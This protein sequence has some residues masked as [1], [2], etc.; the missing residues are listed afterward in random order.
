MAGSIDSQVFNLG[1]GIKAKLEETGFTKF[2][3]DVESGVITLSK[4]GGFLKITN[5]SNDQMKLVRQGISQIKTPYN[6]SCVDSNT[7]NP[8]DLNMKAE[9]L[10]KEPKPL[11]SSAIKIACDLFKILPHIKKL[12]TLPPIR[13]EGLLNNGQYRKK[14]Y[15]HLSSITDFSEFQLFRG[16]QKLETKP[17]ENP[18]SGAPAKLVEKI[19]SSSEFGTVSGMQVSTEIVLSS[20]T[21]YI[22][23]HLLTLE[24]EERLIK[25]KEIINNLSA[26]IWYSIKGQDNDRASQDMSRR[27]LLRFHLATL[28]SMHKLEM[29]CALKPRKKNETIKA[30][31]VRKIVK[32]SGGNLTGKSL[33]LIIQ[34]AH[35]IERLLNLA[36]GDWRFL[37]VYEEL[38]P[39][40]FTSTINSCCN[41]EI[42][43]EL[44]K[45]NTT[46]STDDAETRYEDWKKIDSTSRVEQFNNTC[47]QAGANIQISY[48][49][50]E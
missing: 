5:A 20:P 50:L 42:F 30:Q 25:R 16:A 3:V 8:N 23:S 37:D 27:H 2:V 15:E 40:F 34:R 22:I 17:I 21:V 4:T 49:D 29:Y 10:K 11:S 13:A 31:A 41:F 35:R 18:T 48:E 47:K 46:I 7:R 26:H 28:Q 19:I 44:V 1:F 36:E 14:L 38:T 24:K 12:P 9:F 33:T 32:R 39:C 45:S 43:L 6:F